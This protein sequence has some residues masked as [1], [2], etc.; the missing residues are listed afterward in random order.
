MTP[1]RLATALQRPCT[2]TRLGDEVTRV[3]AT[4]A[5]CELCGTPGRERSGDLEECP[6]CGVLVCEACRPSQVVCRTCEADLLLSA[7]RAGLLGPEPAPEPAL[8][9]PLEPAPESPSE[10]APASAP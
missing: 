5:Y 8:E 7:W 10:P 1:Q 4:T 2:G 6:R 3:G 9:P